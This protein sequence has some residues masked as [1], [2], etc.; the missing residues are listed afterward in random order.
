MIEIKDLYKTFGNVEAVNHLDCVFSPGVTGLVGVNGSGKSTLLRCICGVYA[1]NSGR[2]LVDGIESTE[3][4]AKRKVFFLSDDP[5]APRGS[6]VNGILAFYDA[7]FEIDKDKFAEIV[8]R[9]NLPRNRSVGTFSKGMKRQV[10]IA[11]AIA[12]K[13]NHLLLD[14]AFDG[15]DP[16][17]VDTIKTEVLAAAMEGK[18]VIISSHNIY[19]L[20]NIV[21]RFVILSSGRIAETMETTDMGE[22]FIKYQA[23]F[24]MP[25]NEGNLAALGFK[26]LSFR[27][28][29][30]VIHFVIAGDDSSKTL[31]EDS[32]HPIL[33]EKVELGAE[34]VVALEMRLAR[35]GE[36][37]HD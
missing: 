29:G 7:L 13:A 21:D 34:E 35:E 4:E 33:L 5:Y 15:L 6:T 16:L 12:M 1:P 8:D 9:F 20:Q 3:V 19:A 11:L 2:V 32:L 36:R 18:T 17:V 28:V 23:A 25:V 10:F 31:I 24:P 27:Q 14:E 37:S 22:R 26:V 30:S